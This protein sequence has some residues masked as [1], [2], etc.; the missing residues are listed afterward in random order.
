MMGNLISVL[1]MAPAQEGQNPLMSFLPLILIVL[2]F[3]L[4]MIRPQMKKQKE[5]R[6]FRSQLKK[7]DKIVTTGGIYGKVSEISDQYITVEVA[8]KVKLRLDKNAVLK[9]SGDL[10]TQAK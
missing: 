1:L 4:F 3:Y 5:L 7:G 9:D 8:D 2:V 10:A 6:N